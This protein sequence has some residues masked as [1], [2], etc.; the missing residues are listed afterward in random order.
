MFSCQR[1][2]GLAAAAQNFE[3]SSRLGAMESSEFVIIPDLIS[4][5]QRQLESGSIEISQMNEVL[6]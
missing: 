6:L 5:H 2:Q 1:E 3:G 4:S